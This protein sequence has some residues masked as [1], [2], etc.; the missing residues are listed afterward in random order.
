MVKSEK[1]YSPQEY[2]EL[3]TGNY[4]ILNG[5]DDVETIEAILNT[6]GYSVWSYPLNEIEYIVE[7][8]LDVV[9]VDCLVM[10]SENEFR[11][12]YRWF[13]TDS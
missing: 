13:G 10:N 3:I 5:D 1:L 11:H 6:C 8:K 7:N 12:E 4:Y 2:L 9:L